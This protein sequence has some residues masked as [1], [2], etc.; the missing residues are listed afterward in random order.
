MGWEGFLCLQNC[1]KIIAQIALRKGLIS[2][3]LCN[4]EALHIGSV[5]MTRGN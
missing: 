5:N 2:F 4:R 1:V 3:L